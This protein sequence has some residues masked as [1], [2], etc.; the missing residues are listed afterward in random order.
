[1]V[2]SNLVVGHVSFN[3]HPFPAI[4]DSIIR[5]NKIKE[6]RFCEHCGQALSVE[7]EEKSSTGSH[8]ESA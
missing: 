3:P 2:S 1:M 7:Q 8:F 5:T 4:D 6:T